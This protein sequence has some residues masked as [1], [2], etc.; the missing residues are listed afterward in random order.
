MLSRDDALKFAKDWTEAWNAHDIEKILSHYSESVVLISPIAERL[1][2]NGEVRGM[3]ALREYFQKGLEAYPD[4]EFR[5]QDVMC[6]LRSIVLFYTNQN[7][8]RAGEFMYLDERGK[9]ARVY[10]HYSG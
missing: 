6:G 8:V 3:E 1:L 7:N 2:G 5:L 10:A 4:L 9:I